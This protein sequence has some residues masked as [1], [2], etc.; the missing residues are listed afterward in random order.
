MLRRRDLL[1]SGLAAGAVLPMR[2]LAAGRAHAD[3][4]K[5]RAI[6]DRMQGFVDQGVVA[7]VVTM[8]GLEGQVIHHEAVGFQDL[9][10]RRPMRPDCLFRIASMTKPVTA[11]AFMTLVEQGKVA[12]DDP[13]EKHLPE[14]RGL[15]VVKSKEGD[16]VTLGAP[17]RPPTMKDLLT[18]TSGMAGLPPPGLAELYRK[19]DR[20]LGEAVLAFSQRPLEFEPGAKWSYSNTGIDTVGRVVEVVSGRPFDRYCAERIFAP[21]G[22]TDTS[23]F[24]APAKAARAASLY[25]EQGGKLERVPSWLGGEEGGRYPLPAGGLYSTARDLGRLYSALLDGGRRVLKPETLAE[26]TRVHTG[27]LTTGFVP[28][29]GFGLGVGVVRAPQ[30]VTAM[31]SPGSFGHGGAFGT[32]GWMDPEKKM[33][34]VL[35]VQR[36]GTPGGDGSELRK[37]LQEVAVAARSA[38]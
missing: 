32:Q 12:V 16:A 21:L 17:A 20:A 13:V 19:R 35:L 9:A 3:A 29:M 25:K 10:A 26:M 22:M 6:R 33:F 23:F 27:E 31:L 2:A 8:V 18:H 34:F 15:R 30:G 14:F 5:L 36:D 4:G 38:A 24:L 1:R 7:G 37:A 28:G 11:L